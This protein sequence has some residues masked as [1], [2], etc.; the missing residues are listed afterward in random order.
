[1]GVREWD[2]R[3]VCRLFL[4][5]LVKWRIR[6]DKRERGESHGEGG[7]IRFFNLS[8]LYFFPYCGVGCLLFFFWGL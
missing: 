3:G 1:M 4:F 8:A 6:K 2:N 5:L 7:V